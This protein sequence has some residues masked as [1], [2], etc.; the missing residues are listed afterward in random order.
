APDQVAQ[1]NRGHRL[2]GRAAGLGVGEEKV[3]LADVHQ[4]QHGED[5]EDHRTFEQRPRIA[6]GYHGGPGLR[7]HGMPY[8]FSLLTRVLRANPNARAA[9]ALL[10]AAPSKARSNSSRSRR[11][12]SPR[13]R[14]KGPTGNGVVSSSENG[15]SSGRRSTARTMS[16]GSSFTVSVGASAMTTALSMTFSSCRIF[17]GQWYALRTSR[18]SSS[19]WAIDFLQR[20]AACFK[21]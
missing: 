19:I 15:S 18:A 5:G 20:S 3:G 1:R 21:K 14:P 6:G 13:S 12:R 8:F 7:T 2:G 9:S 4:R 17:P 10:P 11:C 16:S